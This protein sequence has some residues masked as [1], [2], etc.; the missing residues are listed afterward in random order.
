M[1]NTEI[2]GIFNNIADLLE[3][4]GENPFRI[5]AYRKAAFIITALGKDISSLSEA[6]LLELPG[7]GHDLAAKIEEYVET[8]R[9]AAYEKLKLDIPESLTALLAIPGL[10]PKTVAHLY[11]EYDIRDVE[12]LEK[13]AREHRLSGLPGIKDKTE[14]SILKGIEMV[15]RYSARHPLGKVLAWANEIKEYL[16]ASAPVEKLAIAGSLRRWKDTIKDIDIITT[17]KDPEAVMKVFTHMPEVSRIIARGATKSSLL[18]KADIQVDIRVVDEDSYGSALA[19][20]TGSKEHNIRL[21]EIASK[22]GLKI[23]EYGIFREDDG[24]KLGGRTEEDIYHVLGLEYVPPELREDTGE[25]EAAAAGKLPQ[26]IEHSDIKGDLHVHSAW[27]DG[28]QEIED[29]VKTALSKGYRYLAVTD[30]SK[31][32]GVARGLSEERIIEQKKVIDAINRKTRGV[33]VLSGTE[34]NIKSD[35]S[36]D[37]DDEL[38]NQLDIVVASIHSGFKQP[39]EQITR[40]LVTAMKNPFVSIIGHPSGR[41]IGEREAY[42]LDMEEVLKAAA[43]TGTAIE[44]NAYPLRL[45]LNEANVRRAKSMN[46]PLVIST[47]S[48]N[49]GQFDNMI[50]GV[51][52]AKRGWLEKKDVLNTLDC[53]R[54]LKR[55]HKKNL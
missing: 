27:S 33:R 7:V 52:V 15:R 55:L 2:A 50:Y 30:H 44:I 43:D 35:G 54:L 36:L 45:D 9:M 46:V 13:L 38:L 25:I 11:K 34:I 18:L 40:R 21:R 51:A 37:F 8:G 4:K 23:N 22:A 28:A 14:L 5:R 3:I 1:K 17:S 6:E 19:Y 49:S 10:G 53:S 32:L 24:R 16:S 29:L 26:L 47:D 31:G 20:F 12:S 42:E 48:H 41:L 39:A